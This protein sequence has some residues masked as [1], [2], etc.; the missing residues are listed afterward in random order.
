LGEIKVQRNSTRDKMTRAPDG[1]PK[2]LSH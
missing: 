2:L 1:I